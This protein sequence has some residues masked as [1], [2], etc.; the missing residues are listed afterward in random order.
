MKVTSLIG[1]SDWTPY[2][3]YAVT[4]IE[5]TRPGILTYTAST[6]TTLDFNWQ[7]LVG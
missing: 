7:A 5:P 2:L 1:D 3:V 6:R 4:G